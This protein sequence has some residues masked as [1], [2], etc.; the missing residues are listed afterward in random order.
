MVDVQTC[1]V[2]QDSSSRGGKGQLLGGRPGHALGSAGR[3]KMVGI[4]GQER[5]IGSR[6]RH[7]HTTQIVERI[8][9]RVVPA[10][11]T[12]TLGGRARAADLTVGGDHLR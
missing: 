8:L 3:S 1:A 12:R 5:R 9:P 10:H 2:R 6:T 4:V 7:T 11:D